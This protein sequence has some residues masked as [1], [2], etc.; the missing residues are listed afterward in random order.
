M[1]EQP[2]NSPSAP[3]VIA[4]YRILRKLGA[5]GMGE[6]YLAHDTR[7]DREVALKL[8]PPDLADDPM[9]RRRF[10]TEAKAASALNHP[11]VC[12]IHEV[13]E[14]AGPHLYIA[15]EFVAGETLTARAQSARLE[16]RE[17]IEIGTQIADALDAAFVK[18]IVHRDIKPSN[19]CLNERGHVKVLDF[20]LAKRLGVVEEGQSIPT[21]NRTS[22]GQVMGTPHY[23]S[24]EQAVGKDVDHRSDLFS[25]GVVLY[26]L[27][28]GRRP[29]SGASMG[30]IIER[31]LRAPIEA[32]ARF[33]YEVPTELERIIRK[34]LEKDRNSR[35][36]SPRDL[37]VD[38]RNLRRELERSA[39]AGELAPARSAAAPGVPVP[40]GSDVATVV[41]GRAI[42]G[43]P[44]P[45]SVE[46]LKDSDIF[47]NFAS[48]DDQPLSTDQRGWV[49]QLQR[50]LEVRLEQLWGNRLAIG[51]YPMPP[52]D[53]AVDQAFF[54]GLSKVKTMISVVSPSFVKA[55][56]CRREVAAFWQRSS[57]R[58][59]LLAGNKARL[60]KVVKT[61][62]EMRDMPPPLSEIFGRL[63]DFNFFELDPVTGRVREFDESFGPQA[64]QRFF[65]RIY[66]LAQ[67]LCLVLRACQPGK[68]T[69]GTAP[70]NG[71][72]VYLA[73]TTADLRADRDSLRRELLE[74]GHRVLPETLLPLDRDELEASVREYLKQSH[75][76]IHLIGGR[77][78]LIP[79]GAQESMVELQNRWAGAHASAHDLRRLIWIPTSPVPREERQERFIHSLRVDPEFQIGAEV[80]EGPLSTL[81]QLALQRLK[82]PEPSRLTAPSASTDHPPLVYLQCDRVDE[83]AAAELQDWLFEQGLDVS[84][85]DHGADEEEA[86]RFHRENLCACD[87]VLVYFGEV[88]RTWV[89]TR[90]RDLLKAPGFGRT[91]PFAAKTVYATPG[92]DFQKQRFKTHLAEVLIAQTRLDTT[93]L[94]PFVDRL[95]AARCATS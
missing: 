87:A 12:T 82:P 86:G 28:T 46:A 34:C 29:F 22:T 23:M 44:E 70:L 61:P 47:I 21:E 68:Q 8:L 48:I 38:F 79:E 37:L 63:A 18:G 75:V 81:K 93:A 69:A 66:D 7:L 52:G 10:L 20:G 30:E 65:E 62:V 67:E 76:A 41:D 40:V 91:A 56:G 43:T 42:P 3:A 2:V 49:S 9:R 83:P 73:E 24:P 50:H 36:Q 78:G 33:N 13:S 5:G 14:L 54:E 16:I 94:R 6:V 45:V 55:E 11:N 1:S 58:E 53:Q 19:I 39:S 26:E 95:K 88:R 90:L 85:P 60:F 32:L 35:Y 64:K 84:L 57:G 51:R 25:L 92:G 27:V 71:R 77:Y 74:L 31:I 89:E 80:I 17:I 4:H 72:T 59:G 15:M